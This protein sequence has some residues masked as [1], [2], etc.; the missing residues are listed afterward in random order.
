[1]KSVTAKFTAQAQKDAMKFA[2]ADL[3]GDNALTFEE[4]VQLHSAAVRANVSL[5]EIRTWFN[6][7]DED[8]DGTVTINEYFV[9]TLSKA[10]AQTGDSGLRAVFMEYDK[11]GTGCLDANEFQKFANTIGFGAA[12][13]D[14][15]MEVR[16]FS[17]HR[18]VPFKHS[19][20]RKGNPDFACPLPHPLR[21]SAPVC[22]RARSS[23][24]TTAGSS[25]I[26]RFSIVSPA[27][28]PPPKSS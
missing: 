18:G 25:I 21:F 27:L 19:L 16:L 1:M 13:H 11:D 22:M 12:A 8:K 15:F 4:F 6:D 3:N 2:E 10:E 17:L 26:R 9:Y 5:D 23:I 28:D 20:A 24:K 7:C 14:I